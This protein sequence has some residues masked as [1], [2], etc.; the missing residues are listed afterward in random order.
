[1]EARTAADKAGKAADTAKAE[2]AKVSEEL[3]RA[4]KG[5]ESATQARSTSSHSHPFTRAHV[6]RNAAF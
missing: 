4:K 2:A 3:K 6:A 1:M 5:L